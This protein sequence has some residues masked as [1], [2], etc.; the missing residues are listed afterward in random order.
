[1]TLCNKELARV[2]SYTASK[3]L[4]NHMMHTLL[5]L[6]SL[7]MVEEM[8]RHFPDTPAEKRL[9]LAIYTIV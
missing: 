1:M 6:E 2:Y 7:E 9:K 3:C 5:L 4:K 8:S